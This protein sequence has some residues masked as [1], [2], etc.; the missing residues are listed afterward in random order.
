MRTAPETAP[1]AP[2]ASP[3]NS[4]SMMLSVVVGPR[5]PEQSRKLSVA[6]QA[7]PIREPLELP[8][9]VPRTRLTILDIVVDWS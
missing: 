5:L 2:E 4:R 6:E 8:L 3:G 7:A 1:C 9:S